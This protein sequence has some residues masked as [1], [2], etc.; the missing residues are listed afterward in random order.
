MK[1]AQQVMGSITGTASI[2]SYAT[3]ELRGLFEEWARVLE[4]EII[5]F[6]KQKEKTSPSDIAANLSISEESVLFLIEKL[7][8]EGRLILGEIRV[9]A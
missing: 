2:A 3:P 8:R 6:V 7:A 4:E 5:A 1:M 9:P